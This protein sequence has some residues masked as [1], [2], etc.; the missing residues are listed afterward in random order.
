MAEPRTVTVPIVIEQDEDGVWCAHAQLR[1]GLGAHGEGD[2][3]AAALD[4]LR[5]AL[6]A[7]IE[8]F[9]VPRELSIT[10]AA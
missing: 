4:D 10:V 8:E 9:G 7:L 5:E 6:T 2:T 3:E 1:P